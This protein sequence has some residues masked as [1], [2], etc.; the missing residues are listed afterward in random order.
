VSRPISY[1]TVALLTA[2]TA[3]AGWPAS[4]Q[5]VPDH[6]QAYAVQAIEIEVEIPGDTCI[7]QADLYTPAGVDAEHPAPAILTSNGFGGEKDDE[8]QVAG[9][10]AF[11]KAGYVAI[12]Y[13]GLGFGD[14][15]CKIYLDDRDYDGEAGEQIVDVLAG[16]KAY[17]DAGT[18]DED[19][20]DYVA[21]ETAGDPRVGMIG[22]SYGGQNQFAIAAQDDRVDAI[23]PTITWNDLSYSLAPNNTDQAPGTV[24][25]KTP[26]V[27]KKEWI[28]LFFGL[29]IVS[30]LGNTTTT[31]NPDPIV[32]CPNFRNEA[33]PAAAQLNTLGYPDA[34][35]LALARHASVGSYLKDIKIPTLLVQGQNDTLFNIREAVA[36]YRALKK[37]GTTVSMSWF[38]GGHSGDAVDGDLDLTG[39]VDASHQGRRWIGWMDR[40]VRGDSAASVG[41]GFEYFR[42]WKPGPV[43]EAYEPSAPSYS[44]APTSTLFLSGTNRLT[45]SK[46]SVASGSA[47]FNASPAGTSYSE[48]SGVGNSGPTDQPPPS[49][50]PGTFASYTTAKLTRAA[51]LVGSPRLNVRISAPAAAQTQKTG[52]AGKLVLFTKLYDV[53]PDGTQTLQHRLISPVRVK[54]V[55]KPLQVDLPGVAQR[56]AAGHQIR[57]V[58][59]GGDLA[60]AN[61]S[62][63]QRVTVLTSRQDPGTLTLP[64]VNSPTGSCPQGKTGKPPFCETPVAAGTTGPGSDGSQGGGGDKPTKSGSTGTGGGAAAGAGSGAQAANAVSADRASSLPDTGSPRWLLAALALGLGLVTAGS[65]LVLGQRVRSQQ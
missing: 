60:Y 28:D 38:S 42:D 59:A 13:S 61:N 10:S 63:T 14:S 5:A 27:A 52:T 49:D 22:G 17:A 12:S 20:I 43:S 32:G 51:D 64:L 2:A 53:A 41:P 30:G 23:I 24:T 11:A 8:K 45:P 21:T 18:G 58:I 55:T 56:F 37:Q 48:T 46:G 62:T 65:L 33:C 40:Y 4:A 19:T 39:G 29:G 31:A 1:L 25:Y 3:A 9:A 15:D 36:T 57:L 54:D 50:T 6:D 34:T 35:T 47:R 26:G 16:S 44:G 7:V